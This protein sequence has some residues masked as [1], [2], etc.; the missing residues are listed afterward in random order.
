MAS[1]GST[2]SAP[3]LSADRRRRRVARRALASRRSRARSPRSPAASSRSDRRGAAPLDSMVHS[4]DSAMSEPRLDDDDDQRRTFADPSPLAIH[5][6][7]AGTEERDRFS[8][9]RTQ[10]IE[11]VSL[12]PHKTDGFSSAT[13]RLG[14]TFITSSSSLGSA[15]K[16]WQRE[17]SDACCQEEMH[18]SLQVAVLSLPGA[19]PR[20][21]WPV[22]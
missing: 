8:A 9:A 1:H 16:N 21:G 17:D 5:R 10:G 19:K 20:L 4:M 7:A 22:G 2:S 13:R 12:T 14:G 11:R 3:S 6:I 18:S 15:R